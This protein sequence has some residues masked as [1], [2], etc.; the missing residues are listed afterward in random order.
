MV[1]NGT[2]LTASEV[3]AYEL[4][5]GVVEGQYSEGDVALWIRAHSEAIP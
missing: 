2:R 4:V 5:I 3:E 1:L